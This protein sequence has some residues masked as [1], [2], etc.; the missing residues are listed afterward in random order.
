M[1]LRIGSEEAEQL[2]KVVRDAWVKWAKTRP[3]AKP[4]WLVE[5]EAL[6]SSDPQREVDILIGQAVS[7]FLLEKLDAVLDK[8]ESKIGG[9]YCAPIQDRFDFVIRSYKDTATQSLAA[10]KSFRDDML[11]YFRA[12]SMIVD[13]AANAGTHSE[14]NARL[15]GMSE[16]IEQAITKLRDQEFNFR[17][18][19]WHEKDIF[20]SDYPVRELMGQIH[21]L[22]NELAQL[23]GEKPAPEVE[24][25]F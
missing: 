15:R 1:K 20:R 9:R 18:S 25:A 8:H 2:G 13:M 10:S 7:N 4:S 17:R 21:K 22:Q 23:R 16:I 3:E 14:K 11:T 24:E 19:W 5:W 12:M 6:P